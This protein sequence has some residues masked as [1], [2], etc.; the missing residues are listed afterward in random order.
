M[1]DRTQ[2]YT[3]S[4]SK[5]EY[6]GILILLITSK[7]RQMELQFNPSSECHLLQTLILSKTCVLKKEHNFLSYNFELDYF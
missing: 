6:E 2:V 7:F 4:F 1:S 5:P 3:P